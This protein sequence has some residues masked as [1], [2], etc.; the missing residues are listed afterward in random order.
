MLFEEALEVTRVY[1]V[2]GYLTERAALVT[3][4]PFPS[5]HHHVSVSGLI[6]GGTGLA[7]PGEVSLGQIG[8]VLSHAIVILGVDRGRSL[9]MAKVDGH[10]LLERVR[11]SHLA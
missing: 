8:V 2:A 1:S 11:R 9:S 5:P 3:A 4:R 7:R 6:G 10:S